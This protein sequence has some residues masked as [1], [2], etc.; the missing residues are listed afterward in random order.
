MIYLSAKIVKA[1]SFESKIFKNV[2][3]RSN[4]IRILF[5][6]LIEKECDLHTLKTYDMPSQSNFPCLIFSIAT[7]LRTIVS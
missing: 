4:I 3:S 7:F 2:E 1:K 5:T 6:N